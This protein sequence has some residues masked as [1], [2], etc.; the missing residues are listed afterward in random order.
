MSMKRSLRAR[1]AGL[2]CLL[3]VAACS[4]ASEPSSISSHA[5]QPRIAE[6]ELGHTAYFD[7]DDALLRPEETEALRRFAQLVDER[8]SIERI[9]IGHADIRA[10]D[11]HND[12]LSLRRA[13]NV[14]RVL[15]DE[16]LPAERISIHALG[17]RLPVSAED[18]VVSWRLSRRV[19]VLAQGLIVV[20][21]NC[22]D[23]SRPSMASHAMLLSSN[24][25]C[26]TALNLV[27]TLAE[28]R[29]LLGGASLAAANGRRE[30][31]AINRYRSD[32]I[33]PLL[34]ESLGR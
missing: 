17:R 2:C 15:Q 12:A 32:V 16:G 23:W 5:H 7:T 18:E 27:R 10:G 4:A 24:F 22:P 25:G 9:V 3:A 6:I 33:R 30:A 19:E 11:A 28:P 26:A 14:A 29:D 21:P 31:A 34:V 13:T 1:I 20:E 8:L